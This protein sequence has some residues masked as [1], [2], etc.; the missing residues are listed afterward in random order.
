MSNKFLIRFLLEAFCGLVSFNVFAKQQ[1]RFF[2]PFADISPA[3][4]SIAGGAELS[5]IFMNPANASRGDIFTLDILGVSANFNNL[6]VVSD[7]T[8]VKN[9]IETISK[10]KS[11]LEI[12]EKMLDIVKAFDEEL[13]YNYSVKGS[14]VGLGYTHDLD[15]DLVKNFSIGFYP[16]IYNAFVKLNQADLSPFITDLASAAA[17]K[18]RVFISGESILLEG[19]NINLAADLNLGESIKVLSVGLNIK[20]V[21]LKSTELEYKVGDLA[22]GTKIKVDDFSKSGKSYQTYDLGVKGEIPGVQG[23]NAGLVFQ[24]IGAIGEKNGEYYKPMTLNLGVNYTIVLNANSGFL[25]KGYLSADLN[26]IAG[27]YGGLELMQKSK[28]LFGFDVFNYANLFT[29]KAGIG[30]I[31]EDSA[32]L[33]EM[34]LLGL[35]VRYSKFAEYALNSNKLEKQT[36]Q[37]ITINWKYNF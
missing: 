4:Q 28:L 6:N 32:Y 21:L 14:V 12:D 1:Q 30:Y 24:D 34:G 2:S 27:S 23:L 17:N 10:S 7:F 18:D 33:V 36:K 5:D 25:N 15:G 37:A 11:F 3:N 22:D 19:T 26:D 8:D 13:S 35:N 31:S 20:N 9:E 29:I 16:K